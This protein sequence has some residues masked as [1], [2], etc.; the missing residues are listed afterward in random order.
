[1]LSTSVVPS[2]NG[3][4]MSLVLSFVVGVIA[5][6]ALV[7][8]GAFAVNQVL[9]A[10]NWASSSGL[11]CGIFAVPISPFRRMRASWYIFIVMPLS[12]VVVLAV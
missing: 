2:S 4:I 7:P 5:H 9:S 3:S 1:M 10:V 11:P 12:C 8:A 6:V